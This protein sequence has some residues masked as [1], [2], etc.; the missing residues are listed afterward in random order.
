MSI[1]SNHVI[2]TRIK[3]ERL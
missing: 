1:R 2:L 3:G